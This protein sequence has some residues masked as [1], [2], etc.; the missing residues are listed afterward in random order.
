MHATPTPTSTKRPLERL[1]GGVVELSL[2]LMNDRCSDLWHYNV[3]TTNEVGTLMVGA[4]VDEVDT[5][6]I[7]VRSTNGYFQ[8]TSPLHSAYAP[9]HYVLHFLD[10][11][12]G[13][14]TSH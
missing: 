6:D 9:L 8:R 10:G 2:R 5:C 11:P 1:Q 4:D 14:T 7:V 13:M 3:P 12:N